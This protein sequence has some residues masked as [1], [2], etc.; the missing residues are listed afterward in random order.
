MEK[1][2]KEKTKQFKAFSRLGKG[3]LN[4]KGIGSVLKP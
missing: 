1:E 2:G 3:G 4:I